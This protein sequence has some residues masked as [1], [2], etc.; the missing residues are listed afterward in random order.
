VSPEEFRTLAVKIAGPHWKTKLG[1]MIGKC[2]T[3]VWEYASGERDVPETVEK[4]MGFLGRE[5]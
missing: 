1:P 4:L 5:G 2:R 3:Q